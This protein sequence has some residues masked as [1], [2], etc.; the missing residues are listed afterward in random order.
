[1]ESLRAQFKSLGFQVGKE[2][3]VESPNVRVE[4][5]D[6]DDEKVRLEVSGYD[7]P[8]G[9]IVVELSSD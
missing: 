7:F 6:R 1:M 3:P 5:T 8:D 9:Q 4:H 2:E